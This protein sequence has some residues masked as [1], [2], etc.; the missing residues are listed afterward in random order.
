M[1][2]FSQRSVI[3]ITSSLAAAIAYWYIRRKRNMK[4]LARKDS[5]KQQHNY[6]GLEHKVTSDD[7]FIVLNVKAAQVCNE[8]INVSGKCHV[9]DG[10]FQGEKLA[11]VPVAE[12]NNVVTDK[13]MC[14]ESVLKKVSTRCL[15]E[16]NNVPGDSPFYANEV[17]IYRPFTLQISNIK[18]DTDYS[19]ILE[20]VETDNACAKEKA[21]YMSRD[22]SRT[23]EIDYEI[24]NI[25][26]SEK[27]PF[28]FILFNFTI[29]EGPCWR[30]TKC[31]RNNLPWNE[32]SREREK[33]GARD[34]L[35]VPSLSGGAC[36]LSSWNLRSLYATARVGSTRLQHADSICSSPRVAEAGP[37]LFL[38]LVFVLH[39]HWL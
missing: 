23:K 35:Y 9:L 32:K 25:A 2:V 13:N 24:A 1:E 19:L 15:P 11:D 12:L 7:N 20:K 22:C 3:V 21:N 10:N 39:S 30:Q 31:N 28:D 34:S 26:N 17:L 8:D 36:A 29:V 33:G 4:D 27:A 37:S 5:S 16:S 38:H 6:H 14:K 18:K